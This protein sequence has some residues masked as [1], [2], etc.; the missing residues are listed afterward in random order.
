MMKVVAVCP[1]RKQAKT[2]ECLKKPFGMEVGCRCY[3]RKERAGL[4]NQYETAWILRYGISRDVE[5][6]RARRNSGTWVARMDR[7]LS[8]HA[9]WAICCKLISLVVLWIP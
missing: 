6:S 3:K 1:R 4:A 8:A 5:T 9:G 7:I 2:E